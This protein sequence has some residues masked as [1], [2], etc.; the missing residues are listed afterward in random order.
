MKKYTIYALETNYSLGPEYGKFILRIVET[1]TTI[2]LAE[3]LIEAILKQ[4]MW[5][6]KE[7]YGM[8][9]TILTVYS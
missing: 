7:F 8:D 5:N 3:E 1:L 6:Y 4:D 2:E 9:L